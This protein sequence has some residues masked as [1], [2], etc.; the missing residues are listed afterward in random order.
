MGIVQIEER[1]DWKEAKKER[2]KERWE[3]MRA[4]NNRTR[5]EER[6]RQT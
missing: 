2:K 1:M 3:R 5:E 4:E 6:K